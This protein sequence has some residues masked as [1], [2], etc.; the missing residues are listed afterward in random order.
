MTTHGHLRLQNLKHGRPRLLISQFGITRHYKPVKQKL[1]RLAGRTN[2]LK[3][4]FEPQTDWYQYISSLRLTGAL[5]S[6]DVFHKSGLGIQY[7]C[8]GLCGHY[9]ITQSAAHCS[10]QTCVR[11]LQPDVPRGIATSGTI[12]DS[13]SSIIGFPV[14]SSFSFWPGKRR[15]AYSD[16]QFTNEY[17]V[18]V[19]SSLRFSKHRR[20]RPTISGSMGT[21]FLELSPL[22]IRSDRRT[23]AIS[24]GI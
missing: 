15:A 20:T 10:I 13:Q 8:P 6:D 1:A 16:E 11:F 24:H 9:S 17:T 5:H 3:R 21:G 23:A 18:G 7:P 4:T 19:A 14:T 12:N 22:R 2:R